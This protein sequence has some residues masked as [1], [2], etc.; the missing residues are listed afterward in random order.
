MILIHRIEGIVWTVLVDRIR[1]IAGI[2]A[3][4]RIE[5]AARIVGV[6]GIERIVWLILRDRIE[7]VVV[8]LIPLIEVRLGVARCDP[9]EQHRH[10]QHTVF[11]GLLLA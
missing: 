6:G 11:H 5:C 4:Y 8:P 2:V 7:D 9:H 3:V 1:G 10:N